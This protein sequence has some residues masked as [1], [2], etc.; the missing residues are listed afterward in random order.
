M[1]WL[2]PRTPHKRA[3]LGGGAT[4][5]YCRSLARHRHKNADC[6]ESA[7]VLTVEASKVARDVYLAADTDMI[8]QFDFN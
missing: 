7:Y 2:L 4:Q 5:S 3:H 6:S 8:K 1:D